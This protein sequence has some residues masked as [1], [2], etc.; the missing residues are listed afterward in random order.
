MTGFGKSTRSNCAR[1][2]D[3]LAV[4]GFLCAC[5]AESIAPKDPDE[6]RPTWTV[7]AERLTQRRHGA[8]DVEVQVTTEASLH[9][10]WFVLANG[11]E[12]ST[13]RKTLGSWG[14]MERILRRSRERNSA[15]ATYFLW[16][17][18][19]TIESHQVVWIPPQT[20]GFYWAPGLRHSDSN[21]T[22]CEALAVTVDGVALVEPDD[23]EGAVLGAPT[24]LFDAIPLDPKS[25][26][27]LR[28]EGSP[29]DSPDWLHE[30]R[31]AIIRCEHYD[32]PVPG[33]RTPEA[34]L[35]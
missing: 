21:F 9:G 4:L 12:L 29:P 23:A 13:G 7:R 24:P 33:Q 34:R 27:H 1:T 31:L 26:K 18:A 14:P 10:R 25:A 16:Y 6:V 28:D 19:M 11:H 15:G 2:A 5:S 22:V 20:T 30:I 32:Y 3:G 17:L 35:R 8:A